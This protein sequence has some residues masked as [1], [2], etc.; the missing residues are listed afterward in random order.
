MPEDVGAT[1]G[2]GRE[3]QPRRLHVWTDQQVVLLLRAA[4]ALKMDPNSVGWGKMTGC[5]AEMARM[6]R[7]APGAAAEWG[8]NMETT[9]TVSKIR[10]KFESVSLLLASNKFRVRSKDPAVREEVDRLYGQL[11]ALQAARVVVA[12]QEALRRWRDELE[13]HRQAW[14]ATRKTDVPKSRVQAALKAIRDLKKLRPQLD[15]EGN[16]V[17]PAVIL[18]NEDKDDDE[19]H[20]SNGAAAAAAPEGATAAGTGSAEQGT[21][22]EDAKTLGAASIENKSSGAGSDTDSDELLQRTIRQRSSLGQNSITDTGITVVQPRGA[23]HTF[24]ED[25]Q[26]RASVERSA[27]STFVSFQQKRSSGQGTTVVEGQEP[28]PKKAR[29]EDS[30]PSEETCKELIGLLQ[31]IMENISTFCCLFHTAV[32]T[33]NPNTSNHF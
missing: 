2:E 29:I 14:A 1:Q 15:T 23:D 19:E 30:P 22:P 31:K 21:A 33:Q 11:R 10:S 17:F 4:V 20:P 5:Y 25:K 28:E 12:P 18:L 8:P 32:N 13:R 9:L 27:N 6:L 7:E 24:P 16:C 26:R 3:G